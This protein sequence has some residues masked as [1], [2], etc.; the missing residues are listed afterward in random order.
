[1]PL[2]DLDVNQELRV[3]YR[4]PANRGV[5][6]KVRVEAQ[7]VV[8]VYAMTAEGFDAYNRKASDFEAYYGARR[9]EHAFSFAPERGKPWHL[10]IANVSD[11]QGVVFYEAE[12]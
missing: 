6:V 12:W 8:R 1:M 7:M 9:K 4:A 3:E 2:S 10:V 5:H 11:R